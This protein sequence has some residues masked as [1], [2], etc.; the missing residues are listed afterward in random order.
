MGILFKTD[1]HPD[2]KSVYQHYATNAF[3]QHTQQT[4]HIAHQTST[5]IDGRAWENT[6]PWHDPSTS[7]HMAEYCD[8]SR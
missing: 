4:A 5:L 2:A 7:P 6:G 8:T 3:R 1:N